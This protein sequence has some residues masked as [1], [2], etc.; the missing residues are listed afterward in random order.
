MTINRRERKK[1]KNKGELIAC[2]V[3]LFKEHGFAETSIDEITEKADISRGT[4]Y[5]Y[6][7]DKESILV[8]YF[9]NKIAESGQ[10][11]RVSMSDAVGIQAKLNVLLE[12]M[13]QIL[14]EDLDLAGVYF[15][16][17]LKDFGGSFENSQRS[18]IEPLLVELIN[19]AQ[20]NREIRADFPPTVI[21]RNF[22]FL[23]MSYFIFNTQQGSSVEN[24]FDKEQVIELF[25]HGAGVQ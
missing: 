22:Q 14:I 1:E 15:R 17:R 4:L 21:A 5:N 19:T 10:Q 9:Q 13:Y 11:L 2:A 20:A 25:L 18:G 8:A 6:F 3:G 7:P 12:I 24:Q 23:F 16:Y